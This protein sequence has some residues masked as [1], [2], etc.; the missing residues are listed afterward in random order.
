MAYLLQ[1]F[2]RLKHLMKV[3]RTKI[4]LKSGE[5]NKE[6]HKQRSK[7]KGFPMFMLLE[8]IFL[9]ASIGATAASSGTLVI[10][11]AGVGTLMPSTL[12]LT[13]SVACSLAFPS[14][15]LPSSSPCVATSLDAI[16]LCRSNVR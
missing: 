8:V 10:A 5:E 15:A 6:I 11:A 2:C 1:R 3:A 13:F 12:A 16:M 7:Q 14:L 9:G 4:K